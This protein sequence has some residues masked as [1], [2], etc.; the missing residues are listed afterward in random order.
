VPPLPL[1]LPPACQQLRELLLLL[2]VDQQQGRGPSATQLQALLQ[3]PLVGPGACLR[4]RWVPSA[5]QAVAGRC[6]LW[7]AAY[8]PRLPALPPPLLSLLLL[9]GG[10]WAPEPCPIAAAG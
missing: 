8:Y 3:L 4:R 10:W 9:L 1:P 2:Q 5:A 6:L 7:R